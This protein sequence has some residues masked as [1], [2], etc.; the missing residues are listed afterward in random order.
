MAAVD[1]PLDT[2]IDHRSQLLRRLVYQ[3]HVEPFQ[4]RFRRRTHGEEVTG[5]PARLKSYFWPSPKLDYA[6]TY[7][8]MSPWYREVGEL[9]EKLRSGRRWSRQDRSLACKL[10]LNMLRWG[11]MRKSRD[12][13][14]KIVENV[15]RQALGLDYEFPTPMNSGWS[16]VA[17][18]A[19]AYLEGRTDQA[20]HVIWD[21]RVSTSLLWRLDRMLAETNNHEPKDLF[22]AI[23]AVIGRGGSRPRQLQ[24]KW[25][26]AYGS[27]T[28]QFA[29]SELVREIRDILSNEGYPDIH[30]LA[31]YRWRPRYLVPQRPC[32]CLMEYPV[33]PLIIKPLQRPIQT[34]PSI[35]Q[36]FFQP[37]YLRFDVVNVRYRLH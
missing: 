18:L 23:G 3:I 35:C 34:R 19:T 24:L 36:F 16:K 8:K 9:S 13:C 22:P 25:S 27:W 15:F 4:P 11:R 33:S 5:W 30:S 20:P 21:S 28:S 10:T 6:G 26:N 37:L 7:T 1:V 31:R 2:Q 17:A 14:P 12:F 29:G 32:Y